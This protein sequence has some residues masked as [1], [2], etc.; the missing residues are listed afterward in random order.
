MSGGGSFLPLK[1]IFQNK[2]TEKK[3]SH[4]INGYKITK[5]YKS[6][7]VAKPLCRSLLVGGAVAVRLIFATFLF[8]F[9]YDF[10]FFHNNIWQLNAKCYLSLQHWKPDLFTWLI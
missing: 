3:E 8:F 9:E 5:H 7:R 2:K 4:F 10:N 1:I 6:R